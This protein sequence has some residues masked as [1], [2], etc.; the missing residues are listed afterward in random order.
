[1]MNGIAKRNKTPDI[2]AGFDS[3]FGE[4]LRPFGALPSQEI[5][6]ASRKIDGTTEVQIA[7]PGFTKD[8]IQIKVEDGKVLVEA[9]RSSTDGWVGAGYSCVKRQF[10]L[11]KNAVVD[12]IEATAE[13][14]ILTIRIPEAEKQQG[15]E[16]QIK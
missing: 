1:M 3:L 13:N 4:A 7:L 9:D 2:W 8:Q 16:I 11:P 14:G 5:E 6:L 15:L 10:H 12:K